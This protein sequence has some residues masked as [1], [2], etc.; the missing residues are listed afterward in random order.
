[1]T[2]YIG[3]VV[4]AAILLGALPFAVIAHV[5]AVPNDTRRIHIIQDMD[6]QERYKTQQMSPSIELPDDE[7]ELF[8]FADQRVM[9]PLV[10]GTVARDE[11]FE[12]DHFHRGFVAGSGQAEWAT[13]FPAEIT[14]DRA[15]VERGRERFNIYCSLCHGV[16]GYGDGIVHQRANT[17]MMSG[18]NGTNWVQPKNLH[19]E[20][21]REQP[22][23]QIYN[24]ITNGI[25]NMAGYKAQIDVEDR[26]AIVAWVK[27]LQR[28]QNAEPSDLSPAEFATLEVVET[29][30]ADGG[31]N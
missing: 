6:N 5:R 15:F 26:W 27:T 29:D 21:I 4:V 28:S 10:D 22:V 9:R 11:L 30:T 20:L 7:G 17:L 25:R 18:V 12:D 2:K 1:M 23:G 8:L 14:V 16:S 24:S 3:Y 31:G 13:E 19:E